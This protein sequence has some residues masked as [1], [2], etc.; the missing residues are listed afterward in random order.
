ME[1][2]LRVRGVL[3]GSLSNRQA[4]M[5]ITVRI[6]AEGTKAG[7]TGP[8]SPRTGFPAWYTL[9]WGQ[10]QSIST[11]TRLILSLAKP[12]SRGRADGGVW[13][14]Q[15]LQSRTWIFKRQLRTRRQEKKWRQTHQLSFPLWY[16]CV[17]TYTL[18][19]QPDQSME[20]SYGRNQ[21]RE[22]PN[23]TRSESRVSVWVAKVVWAPSSSG[24]F[25]VFRVSL[26]Y[27][28]RVCWLRVS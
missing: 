26:G 11:G 2:G 15:H 21:K 8:K 18:S 17:C 6:R 25:P 13:A 9:L 22:V 1:L 28:H 5:P 19:L 27:V 14:P 16:T 10:P 24:R 7:A 4:L 3:W 23:E 20:N 12:L